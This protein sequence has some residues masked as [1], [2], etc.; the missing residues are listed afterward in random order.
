M[1][2][3]LMLTNT[4]LPHVGGV[5]RSVE[6]FTKAFRERGH[7]VIVVAPEFEDMP[8]DEVDVIRVPALQKFNGSDFSVRLPIPGYVQ[9][10]LTEFKPD[11]VH[12]H[13]PFLLGENALRIAASEQVP[14]VYTHHTMYEQYTHYVPGSSTAMQRFVS[15]LSTDFANLCERVFAPSE[16]VAAIV[17]QRGVT[18]PLDVVPT[19]VDIAQFSKGDG[20]AIRREFNIPTDAPVIGH[21]G[22]LAP[23]KN[24]NF[25]ADAIVRV[26][27]QNRHARFLVIGSGPAEESIR[28]LFT[29]RGLADR[30]IMPGA[31]SGQAL[32]DVFHAMDVFVFASQSETQGMVLSEAMAAGVPVV[33][34]DAPGA[35]EVV[36]DRRNGRLLQHQSRRAFAEAVRW[37]L[38]K[39][40]ADRDQLKQAARDTAQQFSTDVCADR[41]LACYQEAI[42]HE[43]R[44]R[45]PGESS[46]DALGRL[47]G[48]E[49]DLWSNVAHS[50]RVA[51]QGQ[52]LWKAPIL[53]H[54]LRAW[55]RVRRRI[56]R[57][58]W[59]PRLLGL[60][61]SEGTA[62][63]PGI[64][65]IQ[66]DGFSRT[67]LERALRRGR[68]PFLRRLMARERYQLQTMYSGV[69]ATT[70]SV[71]GELFYGVRQIVPSFSFRDRETGAVVWMIQ[72]E[73]ADRVQQR[74]TRRGTP[75]LEGGSAYSNIYTGG[76][77]EAH[78]CAS[79]MGWG[80]LLQNSRLGAILLFSVVNVPSF[81][82]MVVGGVIEVFVA[83]FDAIYG[84]LHGRHVSPE[85]RMMTSRVAVGVLLRDMMVIGAGMDTARGLPIVQLNFLGYDEQAHRRGPG[86]CYAHW[87]LKGIDRAIRRITKAARRSNRRDYQIWI[88]SDHG[89]EH[90]EM[91]DKLQGRSLQDAVNE[92]F[93][94]HPKLPVARHPSPHGFQSQRAG[95]LGG[96]FFQKLL[97]KEKIP[98]PAGETDNNLVLTAIGPLGYIYPPRSYDWA[99]RQAIAKK[100]VDQAAVPLVLI[101]DDD[102]QV[103]AFKPEA[104]FKL[105]DEPARALGADHPFL[106][107]VAG[108]LAALCH[109]PDAGS[110]VVSGWRIGQLP[111]SFVLENGAHAGPGPEETNAFCLLPPDAPVE[112]NE[113][114]YFRPSELRA[115]VLRTLGRTQIPV[116][117]K[118]SDMRAKFKTIRVMTYNVHTCI[119]MDGKLSPARIARA[120]AQ[121]DVDV[122]ALQECDV[123]RRRTGHADQVREIARLLQMEFQFFPAVQIAS[124]QYGD[125]ILSRLPMRL[126][127]AEKLPTLDGRVKL[128]PR[129]ALWVEIEIAGEK[130]NLFNTH[131]GLLT[132]ERLA[133]VDALLG[134]L[135]LGAPECARRVIF[136]GDMNAMP[137]SAPYKKLG[138]RLADA[139]QMLAGHR[140]LKTWFS[141][142]PIGRIDH[143]FISKDLHV[144]SVESPRTDF[145]R[146]ASDHLPLVIELRLDD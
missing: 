10:Q 26:L 131:L 13:H 29:R 89:Q 113:Q 75:L 74:L 117:A 32:V 9:S 28:A 22:R 92:V 107:D 16:S 136:C 65:L 31:Q 5:A 50:A 141:R 63:D 115:G 23:E 21:V 30:L 49:W 52:Y 69:P 70:P 72:D 46:I 128:E 130:V 87:S 101:A 81:I 93:E 33:A 90:V 119:G 19:G 88:Y 43:R 135:W 27:Q 118:P 8:A 134:P 4:Y 42:L 34:V 114:G 51:V 60:P 62:T 58:E 67:Q 108:D 97:P 105:L 98:K 82:R 104:A 86:S 1:L 120:I 144:L 25:L 37:V 76:A 6:S 124:E 85:F 138:S 96:G 17:R 56:S 121:C 129:G 79:V 35:R 48:I 142:F 125:A 53:G 122:V 59:G 99:E 39:K 71:Q 77:A 11:I 18:S 73:Q 14:L 61:M 38:E 109:H 24:L 55:R 57:S 137:G 139:Q 40:P 100:L 91:Y 54:A 95:W 127:R 123:A 78:F 94:E 103:W 7:R 143:V 112:K 47:I 116:V 110:F 80:D 84:V 41:A 3:I 2:K 145:I 20:A 111:V 36:D 44:A 133:Q 146:N 83:L 12:A 45:P 140:P 132:K 68:M 64:V 126:V 106:S 15:Q 66:I 102:A